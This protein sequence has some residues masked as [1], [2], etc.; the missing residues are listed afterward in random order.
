MLN[1][2]NTSPIPSTGRL[3]LVLGI[4]IGF[5]A[6]AA[7]MVQVGLER[8]FTPFYL[9][10]TGSVAAI[11][12]VI[13]LTRRV[14]IVRAIVL[15]LLVGLAGLEWFFLAMTSVPPYSGPLAEGAPFP[16]FAAKRADGAPFTE[17]DLKGDKATVMVFIRG[18]W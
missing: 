12:I 18:R 15:V 17:A 8:F 2:M 6:P 13:A 1:A 7:L 3:F 9:P 5:L 16:R 10:I 14:T 4:L 11:L